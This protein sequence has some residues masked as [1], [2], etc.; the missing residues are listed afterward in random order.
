M[1]FVI[2]C[3]ENEDGFCYTYLYLVCDG[4]SSYKLFLYLLIDVF[5]MLDKY[6]GDSDNIKP[7]SL[8][9]LDEII[10][11]LGDEANN[12]RDFAYWLLDLKKELKEIL[13]Y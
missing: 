4:N 6:K 8:F 10:K 13:S 5:D 1:I 2:L 11:I 12:N 7:H 9:Y 3:I